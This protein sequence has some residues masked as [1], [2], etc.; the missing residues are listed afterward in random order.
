[1]L[2]NLKLAPIYDGF[3]FLAESTRN[4]PFLRSHHHAELEL[5][6]VVAGTI[7]YVVGGECFSFG[8]RSLLWLFPAQE[9]QLVDRSNDARNFVAVFKPGLIA[10]ACSGEA[11]RGLKRKKGAGRGILHTILAPED[12]DFLRRTMERVTEG[13]GDPDVL[14]RE[15]GF[16]L[17]SDFRYEHRD[18]D[19]LNAG[20][21]HLLLLCWRL[22]Q[23]GADRHAAVCLHPSI[24]KAIE[25][26]SD[27]AWSGTF[28][29]LARRCGFSEAHFSR[30]FAR[31]VGVPLNRY[32]NSLRMGRF[33]ECLRKPARPT[34]IEAVY[35]AG[36]GSYAQFYKVFVAAYGQGPRACLRVSKKAGSFLCFPR[37]PGRG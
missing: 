30:T 29:Q 8:P 20:L 25:I 37:P 16:G 5:N 18:P 15:A 3:I 24:L 33:W 19:G 36:F 31:Q 27:N 6:L 13:S 9:H 4:P 21:C 1:M 28:A 26:L 35:E 2:Q 23:A 14:N 10:R 34:L 11:Y 17:V 7:T 12:F 32:R 22:Q